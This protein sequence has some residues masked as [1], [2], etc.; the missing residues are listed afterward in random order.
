MANLFELVK[1][2]PA[3]EAAE[4]NGIYL[5]RNGSKYWACCPLHGEKTPSMCFYPDG[6]WYCYGCH[7]GGDT[8]TLYKE[9]YSLENY[10]AACRIADDF[11]IQI[12]DHEEVVVQKPKISVFHHEQVLDRYKSRQWDKFCSILHKANAVLEKYD[13]RTM[14]TAW[15]AP[16]FISAMIAKIHASEQLDWLWQATFV[17]LAKEYK[18]G[19]LD[20]RR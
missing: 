6:G 16:E 15:D 7:R 19:V 4:R 5:K 8:I 1:G 17:D 13:R 18:E 2:I 9:L 14:E 10:D 11:G 3:Y 20:A 12:P